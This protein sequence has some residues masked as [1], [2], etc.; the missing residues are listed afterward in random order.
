MSN[1]SSEVI[2]FEYDQLSIEKSVVDR[3]VAENFF[4][5]QYILGFVVFGGCFPMSKSMEMD[6]E[7][8]WIF[9]FECDFFAL[10]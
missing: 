6:L 9:E 2:V 10:A 4:N 5:M 8:S 7:E 1:S 3:F